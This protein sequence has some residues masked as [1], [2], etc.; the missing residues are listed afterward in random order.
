MPNSNDPQPTIAVVIPCYRETTHILSVLEEIGGEVSW[1]FVVDDACPENT[2]NLVARECRDPRVQIISHESN[3]G[4]GG[5]TMTGY[6]ASIEAGADVIVK[7]DGDGQMDPAA[8]KTLV[9]PVISG[10]ADY[11]KGNRFYDIG[12]VMSMP[13]LR[14]FG[15]LVLSFASKLSSGYWHI[16]DPTNGYTAI[17][18]KVATQ[19]PFDKI[20]RGYF[21]ESDLLFHLNIA[22]ALVADIPIPARYGEEQSSLKI[23]SILLPFT[24]KHS[25]NLLR[26]IIYSYFL[27]DFTIASIELILGLLLVGFG[28]IFGAMEWLEGENTG[29]PATA[30]TVI[31]AALPFLVGS[32]L[33]ISFLNFDVA[34][35]PKSPLH[36]N[37]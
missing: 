9:R 17:H 32:Q 8:I 22:R 2:G 27:R 14:L 36:P 31:L 3:Q 26:R 21:F 18:R 1:I 19:M 5:A 35:Q 7:I 13:K 20:D 6:R 37:L 24:W 25:K 30:G 16:F 4:V 10:R 33:L 11:A 28:T 29:I 23:G 12:G 15:N 34:N